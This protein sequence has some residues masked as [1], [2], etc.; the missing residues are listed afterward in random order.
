M[1]T[2]ITTPPPPTA[3]DMP[4]TAL[5]IPR[6]RP[7]AQDFISNL[8]AIESKTLLLRRTEPAICDR[9]RVYLNY[10]LKLFNERLLSDVR[11]F[12][13]T[14]L[15][16]RSIRLTEAITDV[17]NA[18]T[19][20]L[21]DFESRAEEFTDAINSNCTS[22]NSTVTLREINQEIENLRFRQLDTAGQM[23]KIPEAYEEKMQSFYRPVERIL[24]SA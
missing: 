13:N 2:Q 1:L 21:F 15:T 3:T 6:Y 16:S 17:Q 18:V 22:L 7:R 10:K 4:N 24:N 23:A 20:V 9:I 14:F 11:R 19:T 5:T 8:D 12:A